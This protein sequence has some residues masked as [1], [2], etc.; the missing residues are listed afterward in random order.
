MSDFFDGRREVGNPNEN[1]VKS[2]PI[3]ELP[4]GRYRKLLC[5]LGALFDWGAVEEP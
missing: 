3:M 1:D 2:W 5:F 4:E